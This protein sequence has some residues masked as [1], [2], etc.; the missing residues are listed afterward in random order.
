MDNIKF[1]TPDPKQGLIN[2]INKSLKAGETSFKVDELVFGEPGVITESEYNTKISARCTN[3]RYLGSKLIKYHRVDLKKTV[4]PV[5][6]SSN[7]DKLDLTNT[8]VKNHFLNSLPYTFNLNEDINLS[9]SIKLDGKALT[10]SINNSSLRYA[11]GEITIIPFIEKVEAGKLAIK[12]ISPFYNENGGPQMNRLNTQLFMYPKYYNPNVFTKEDLKAN[13]RSKTVFNF[14]LDATG[15]V[16]SFATLR[17]ELCPI[18]LPANDPYRVKFIK[19][20][21]EEEVPY[22]LYNKYLKLFKE[23]NFDITKI[24]WYPQCCIDNSRQFGR[25]SPATDLLPLKLT[26]FYSAGDENVKYFFIGASLASNKTVVHKDSPLQYSR[27]RNYNTKGGY[28]KTC[29]P[30]TEWVNEYVLPKEIPFHNRFVD[31]PILDGELI[32]YSAVDG[33]VMPIVFSD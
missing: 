16:D 20:N 17:K 24:T 28:T 31:I 5:S 23:Q 7:V 15:L 4:L 10:V 26:P 14:G 19:D 18:T 9:T 1:E 6:I 22:A 32:K 11:P 8:D 29:F 25:I 13:K 3:G 27:W 30:N 12:K 21:L 2:L 33:F